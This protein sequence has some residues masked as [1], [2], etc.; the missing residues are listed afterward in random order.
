MRLVVA[1]VVALLL[2]GGGAATAGPH[3]FRG[4]RLDDALR[5]LQHDGLPIVFSS[6][7]V[8]PRMRVTAEPRATNPRQQLDEILAPNGLNAEPGP[9]G[10]ILVV[11]SHVASSMPTPAE[12]VGRR[13]A[14]GAAASAP[15]GASPAS[16]T[17]HVTVSSTGDQAASLGVSETTLD[18]AALQESAG[19]PEADGMAAVHAMPRVSAVD[20]FRSDFSVR[21]SPYRQIGIVIDGVPTRWL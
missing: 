20:D 5:L 16:Y 2:C 13:H 4:R 14:H 6:E 10:V 1:S 21:G 3:T 7:I 17:D 8:T 11:R 19:V 12:A 15:A 9:G 18:H